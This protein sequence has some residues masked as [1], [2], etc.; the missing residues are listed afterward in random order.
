MNQP[1]PLKDFDHL[2]NNVTKKQNKNKT[3]KK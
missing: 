3:T 1:N 2:L